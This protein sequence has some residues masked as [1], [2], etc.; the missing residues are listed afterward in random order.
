[1]DATPNEEWRPVVGWEDLYEI[2]DEGRVR[3]LSRTTLFVD[4]RTRHFEGKVLKPYRS[5]GPKRY[6][7][8][9][10]TRGKQIRNVGVHLLVLEAFVGPCPDGKN[11]CHWNDDEAD[12]R[13]VNLRWDT[14]SANMFDRVR[15]GH[16]HHTSKTHCPHGHEYTPENLKPN[17]HGRRQCRECHNIDERRRYH[18][19]KNMI[20]GMSEAK[21]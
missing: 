10:L 8:V 11:G 13:L 9:A 15:N 1:V 20:R 3:S 2:S 12:N 21:P 4:G 16:C 19:R 6:F 17:K 5:P 7:R 14:H 18:A